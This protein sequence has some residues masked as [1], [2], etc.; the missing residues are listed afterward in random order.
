MLI[1]SDVS[2][3]QNVDGKVASFHKP[4]QEAGGQEFS[5]SEGQNLKKK[6]K[7]KKKLILHF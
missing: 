3:I 6:K 2:V 7:K 1:L 4:K 5:F